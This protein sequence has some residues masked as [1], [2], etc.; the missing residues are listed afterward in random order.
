MARE[1]EAKA[2]RRAAGNGT[3][4]L[5]HATLEFIREGAGT[6]D[7]HRLLFSAAANLAEFGCTPALAVALLEESALDSGLPPK[8]VRRGIEC[9]LAAVASATW[10]ADRTDATTAARPPWRQSK[11]R[12]PS[13]A[14]GACRRSG[15]STATR[16]MATDT[17]KMATG[18]E[19]NTP[20]ASANRHA[21]SASPL[22]VL[23]PLPAP[24][25]PLPPGAVG[26]GTLDK[27][28]RCGSREFVDVAIS[29]GRSRRDCRKCG[30]FLGFGQWYDERGHGMN[31][32]KANFFSRRRC[33]RRLA[34]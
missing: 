22:A 7:R 30:R 26:S 3:P 15:Q 23:P 34:R 8:D 29:E 11:R 14:S 1:G 27:P 2:A 21:E 28:C 9:G 10:P 6:G 5:N 12:R 4:T 32:R 33:F 16:L 24:L 19:N 25:A 18:N 31:E 20:V 17:D 13:I